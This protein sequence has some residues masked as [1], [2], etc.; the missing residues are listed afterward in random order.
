MKEIS[1][2]DLGLQLLPAELPARQN[3]LLALR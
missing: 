2:T 1:T 3:N